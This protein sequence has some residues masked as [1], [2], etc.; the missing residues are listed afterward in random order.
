M[1]SSPKALRCLVR[2]LPT[3]LPGEVIDLGAGWGTLLRAVQPIYPNAY[4]YEMSWVPYLSCK[5]LGV[6]C[7]R[8]DF[9][10]ADLS[11]AGLVL[12]YL[13]PGAMAQLKEKFTRELSP[14]T[15]IL[16]NTFALPGWKPIATYP[17]GDLYGSAWLHYI[18]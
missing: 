13:Y 14:G 11:S 4:G 12:C 6:R 1:P 2:H 16:S 18:V 3:D 15:H 17:I 5:L 8:K 9:Y 7:L 10:A